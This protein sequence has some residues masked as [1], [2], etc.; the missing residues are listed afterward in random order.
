MAFF[1]AFARYITVDKGISNLAIYGYAP[2]TNKV[3]TKPSGPAVSLKALNAIC[4]A[5][6]L[7]ILGSLITII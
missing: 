6:F 5:T 3:G 1:T 2:N 4:R 7:L